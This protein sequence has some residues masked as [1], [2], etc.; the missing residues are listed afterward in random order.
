MIQ[1]DSQL[2]VGGIPTP[3]EKKIFSWDDDIPNSIESHKNH[4]P[5]HQADSNIAIE[6]CHL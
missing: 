1:P 6:N 2:L 4:V 3:R 5:N